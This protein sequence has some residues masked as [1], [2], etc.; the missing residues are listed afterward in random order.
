MPVPNDLR[1]LP[2]VRG[3]DLVF[4]AQ[5]AHRSVDAAHVEIVRLGSVAVEPFGFYDEPVPSEALAAVG[6]ALR[7]HAPDWLLVEARP[8]WRHLRAGEGPSPRR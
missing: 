6:D 8:A 4:V 1:A 2:V 5:S 3:A 7:R